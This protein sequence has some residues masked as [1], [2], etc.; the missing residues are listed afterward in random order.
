[1]RDGI[2]LMY[3]KKLAGLK[4]MH[5]TGKETKMLNIVVEQDCCRSFNILWF[6]SMV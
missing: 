4:E 1:M 3:W 6:S 2:I 5:A